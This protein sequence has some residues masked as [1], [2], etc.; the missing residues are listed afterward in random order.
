[1]ARKYDDLII[2]VEMD[3][4]SRSSPALG[5]IDK[6]LKQSALE[7]QSLQVVRRMLMRDM[8]DRAQVTGVTKLVAAAKLRGALPPATNG[9]TGYPAFD[10]P[11]EHKARGPYRKSKK[12]AR[13]SHRAMNTAERTAMAKVA[14]VG[15]RL[16]LFILEHV[17]EVT[18]TTG[19]DILAKLKATG[20]ANHIQRLSGVYGILSA[21]NLL[22]HAGTQG[23]KLT[24]KGRVFAAKLRK[25]LEHDGECVPG[26][27]LA[28]ATFV[29]QGRGK[30]R[31][32]RQ[33][34]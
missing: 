2:D 14:I 9:A 25:Q 24:A 18:F 10:S 8:L 31:G 27:Y 33:P 13:T 20:L 16:S 30:P 21:G 11:V 6:L 26:G 34:S 28:P 3:E 7:T 19:T 17:N 4:P 23:Y 5:Q 12:Q 1:M 15:P 29:I 22:K 32:Y